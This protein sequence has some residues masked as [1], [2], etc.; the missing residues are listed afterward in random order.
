[1]L[2]DPTFPV[3]RY[4]LEVFVITGDDEATWEFVNDQPITADEGRVEI[5][6]LNFPATPQPLESVTRVRV[7]YD[8]DLSTTHVLVCTINEE[9]RSSERI[10]VTCVTP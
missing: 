10:G 7:V 6:D 9:E 3:D 1:M 8:E 2:A 4:D 5:A